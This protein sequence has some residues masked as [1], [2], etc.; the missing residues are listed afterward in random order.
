MQHAQM[1]VFAASPVCYKVACPLASVKPNELWLPENRSVDFQLPLPGSLLKSTSAKPD[2]N[3]Q[4]LT[5]WAGA[6]YGP[7]TVTG[8]T[9]GRWTFQHVR[10]VFRSN[11][12]SYPLSGGFRRS[13]FQNMCNMSDFRAD[14][15]TQWPIFGSNST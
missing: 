8:S 14:L 11:L 4:R 1:T 2:Y 12:R 9:V 6:F 15:V 13:N 7:D 10:V 3:E 5:T